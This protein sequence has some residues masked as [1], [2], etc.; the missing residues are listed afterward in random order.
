MSHDHKYYGDFE[1]YF[2]VKE[3]QNRGSKHGNQ[4][5][6]IKFAPL[7]DEDTNDDIEKFVDLYLS[8]YSSLM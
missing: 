8:T 5:I 6:W 3:F 2:Y 4:L 1:D 7:Y